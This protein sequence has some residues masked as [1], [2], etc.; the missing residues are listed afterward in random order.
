MIPLNIRPVYFLI[1][2]QNFPVF[3]AVKSFG[4]ISGF[5]KK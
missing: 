4:F 2:I 5:R 1:M 3:P